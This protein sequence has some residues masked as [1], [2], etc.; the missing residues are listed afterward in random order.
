[1]NIGKAE[2]INR[3]R[4]YY[5]SGKL[6]EI[7]ELNKAGD[8][9]INLG[10]G[11]PDMAPPEEI[12]EELHN[13]SRDPDNHG[14][15]SYNGIQPLRNAYARWYKRFFNVDLDPVHEV[16]PLMGSKEGIFYI[17]LA[18]LDPGDQVLLPDPGYPT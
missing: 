7:E 15:Q 12:I 2:R 8:P 14:Y 5:F 17:S 6:K 18:F 13:S 10:I 1:M 16:L 4:E 9:I 11:N 3:I